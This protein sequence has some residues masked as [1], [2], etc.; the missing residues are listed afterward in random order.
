LTRAYRSLK[1]RDD[2]LARNTTL[3]SAIASNA[4][5]R[6][7]LVRFQPAVRWPPNN[8]AVTQMDHVTQ[9]NA[10]LVEQVAAE[11]RSLKTQAGGLM[12]VVNAFKVDEA[13]TVSH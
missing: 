11:A 8:Q 13:Q 5:T 2:Q 12:E 3:K 1:E 9:R 4:R 10:A 6:Q 7:T